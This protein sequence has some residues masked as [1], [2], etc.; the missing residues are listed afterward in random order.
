VYPLAPVLK[1][2]CF[3]AEG[4]STPKGAAAAALSLPN[5]GVRC[6]LRPPA[7]AATAAAPGLPPGGFAALL[8][9]STPG[10]LLLLLLLLACPSP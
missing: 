3:N 1:D 5:G 7:A 8:V 6:F 10:G 9:R 2:A 4:S